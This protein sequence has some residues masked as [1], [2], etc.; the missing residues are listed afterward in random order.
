M[1]EQTPERPSLLSRIGSSLKRGVLFTL[2]IASLAQVQQAAVEIEA[3]NLIEAE[4]E[5][6]YEVARAN[7][8]RAQELG[9]RSGT[10]FWSKV[11]VQIARRT[12]RR[13]ARPLA[14]QDLPGEA[15]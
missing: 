14:E 12:G 10:R 9:S 5:K 11:A 2:G 1:E 13:I 15:P 6:A 7:A 8:A 4:G 3:E